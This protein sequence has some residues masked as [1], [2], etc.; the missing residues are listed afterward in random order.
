M[1]AIE[2]ASPA[3]VKAR[4]LLDR[5]ASLISAKKPEGHCHGN[6]GPR[7]GRT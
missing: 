6:I 5:F 2:T 3:I 1:V 4:N 7:Y